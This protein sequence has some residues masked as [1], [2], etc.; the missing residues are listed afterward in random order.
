MIFQVFSCSKDITNTENR[1]AFITETLQFKYF[2]TKGKLDS[3]I[4]ESEKLFFYYKD[5]LIDSIHRFVIYKK[6][7]NTT[8]LGSYRSYK[9]EYSNGKLIEEKTGNYVYD[10]YKDTLYKYWHYPYNSTKYSYISDTLIEQSWNNNPVKG[11]LYFKNKNLIKNIYI[12]DVLTYEYDNKFNPLN[13][14][15]GLNKLYNF[16]LI[17]HVLQNNSYNNVMKYFS[18]NETTLFSIEYNNTQN[19]IKIISSTPFRSEEIKY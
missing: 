14:F 17:S 4:G 6:L 12:D 8:F 11:Y 13:N 9:F 7:D 5:S 2:Q 18:R 19:P 16:R 3:A 10:F 1:N 15:V